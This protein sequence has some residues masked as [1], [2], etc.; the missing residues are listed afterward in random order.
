MM[1]DGRTQVLNPASI[2][3]LECWVQKTAVKLVQINGQRKYGGPPPRCNDDIT[4]WPDWTGPVPGPGCEVFISQIP[5]DIYED[6]LIPLFQHVAPL[7]EFRLMMNFSGQ[8]RGFA[9]AKYG[10]PL[11]AGVAIRTLHRHELQEGAR[12]VVRRSTEKRQLSLGEMPA[13][14]QRE[15]LLQVLRGIADG[16]ESLTLRPGK[17]GGVT[18]VVQYTSHYT[19]SMAKKVLCEAFKK[20]FDIM[21]TVKWQSFSGKPRQDAD[22]AKLSA[23]PPPGFP[24][25]TL[26]SSLLPPPLLDGGHR[27]AL[28]QYPSLPRPAR[29]GRE[30]LL[31]GDAVALLR[32][33]CDMLDLGP[34]LYSTQYLCSSPEGFLCFAFRVLIPGVPLPYTGMTRV[35]PGCSGAAQ[36]EE[37]YHAAAEHILRSLYQA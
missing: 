16:V 1:E 30:A 2:S 34:P 7:Y 15:Q 6:R 24:Q 26:R 8:N 22:Q 25:V 33:V 3:S 10:D 32:K 11:H 20:R 31:F 13:G 12:L 4:D 27:P 14:V 37:V 19:A 28:G 5:R 9:Y 29:P 23:S 35:L 36:R 17:G 21:I 18:A